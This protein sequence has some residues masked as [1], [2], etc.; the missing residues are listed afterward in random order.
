VAPRLGLAD[1]VPP[2]AACAVRWGRNMYASITKFL[3]FQACARP[4]IRVG[5]PCPAWGRLRSAP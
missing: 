2:G 4:P 1:P 5:L 3:Q